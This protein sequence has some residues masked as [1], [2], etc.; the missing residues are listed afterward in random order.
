M[1]NQTQI[2]NKKP[3]GIVRWEAV[4]PFVLITL[5][6][7]AYFFFFFDSHLRHALQFMGTKINGAEVNIGRVHSSFWKA[8]FNIQNIE[9]THA[10]Y[11]EKNR[12]QL[13][14]VELQ[15]LWDALLRGKVVI[16]T[17]KIEDV[18]IGSPRKTPGHV[19][20]PDPPSAGESGKAEQLRAD[21]LKNISNEFSKNVLGDA[22]SLLGGVDPNDQL[23]AM[24]GELKSSERINALQSELA[25]KEKE[26]KD[27]IAALGD[28]KEIQGFQ[29][30]LKSIKLDK[31]NNPNE[32]QSTLREIDQLYKDIE[33]K[34]NNVK[35][36]S[37]SLGTDLSETQKTLTNLD[38]LIKDDIKALEDR[39]KIPQLD[40]KSITRSL[41]GP[42]IANR[43]QMA[44]SYISK[45]RKYLPPKK[46][47]EAH[48]ET[49]PLTPHERSQGRNYQFGVPNSYPLFWLQS[50]KIN[51]HSVPG[52]DWSGD[53]QGT[54]QDISSDPPQLGRPMIAIIEGNF[55]SQKLMG[56]KGEL[57]IDHTKETPVE[58]L[59]LQ[60]DQYPVDHRELL[61][62]NDL[63]LGIAA[64]S[65]N[66]RVRAELLGDQV[67]ILSESNFRRVTESDP[68][69]K[70]LYSKAKQ[71]ILN[72]LLG[73][74]LADIQMVSLNAAV[75]GQWDQLQINLSSNLG[76]L[77]ASAFEKQ[78]QEK[79]KEAK[80][81][82]Q[83][84]IDE[85]VGQEKDK[86]IAEF[87]KS[88]TQINDLLKSKEGE[89]NKFKGQLDSSKNEAIKSQSKKLENE[90]KKLLEDLKKNF[91]F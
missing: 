34:F 60:V 59:N 73:K 63:E 33:N 78:V 81:Q 85:K 29:N 90:G 43:L 38:Q 79:I 77:L 12:L 61:N 84:F 28:D 6:I 45:A 76:Q 64:G 46:N 7:W 87:K 15:L 8:S 88:Q 36:T 57:I 41:F 53:L 10:E 17:A 37:Q 51:S 39:L 32:V 68:S 23:K 56:I 66:T 83:K 30:R 19:L 11:P 70:L 21:T 80:K 5:L 9:V 67:S 3:K 50:A 1:M 58:K 54:L 44:E 40:A 89:I 74:T 18:S 2:K 4:G 22:A 26:W 14:N 82:I 91:K 20:P 49:P 13:G 65:G 42:S 16:H 55:P 47:K 86:L 31:F 75:K 25:K 35:S 69:M 27:R 62:S 71:P 72:E 52:A 24:E 48:T